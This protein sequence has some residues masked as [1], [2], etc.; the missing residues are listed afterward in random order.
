MRSRGARIAN[1]SEGGAAVFGVP[2]LPLA[3]CDSAHPYQHEALPMSTKLH[4]AYIRHCRIGAMIAAACA[5]SF[6]GCS[7]SGGETNEPS[8]D[9]HSV[10][11]PASRASTVATGVHSWI[12]LPRPAD[13]AI[14][15]TGLNDADAEVYAATLETA[16]EGS[17]RVVMLHQRAPSRRELV[18]RG[19]R[20]EGVATQ[21]EMFMALNGVLAAS[22][23]AGG[24]G[25]RQPA[26]AASGGLR[27]Q[28]ALV[29]P[30]SGALLVDR[31]LALLCSG[32]V[33][34]A[35]VDRIR[36]P[37]KALL[38]GV[39]PGSTQMAYP[40]SAVSKLGGSRSTDAD[41]ALASK[42]VASCPAA[43]KEGWTEDLGDGCK[44][45]VARAGAILLTCAVICG[46][47]GAAG[48]IAEAINKCK[49]TAETIRRR[50]EQEGEA[51]DTLKAI[52]AAVGV[53]FMGVYDFITFA[54]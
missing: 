40:A 26:T 10:A 41:A 15:I 22:V 17:A 1:E 3:P 14:D 44:Q 45:I 2:C 54:W 29:G 19:G 4:L 51:E 39:N 52:A 12:A 42:E 49:E 9:A 33:D 8:A 13:R 50:T 37:S 30:G 25:P 43:N 23:D 32:G 18:L 5:M 48:E 35:T 24:F 47:G 7:S 46:N 6:I 20:T 38:D 27:P 53:V 28:D 36:A 31:G 21:S 16:E 34:S 11:F